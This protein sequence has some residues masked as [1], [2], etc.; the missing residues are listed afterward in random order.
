MGSPTPQPPPDG[1]SRSQGGQTVVRGQKYG[2]FDILQRVKIKH[3]ND[4]QVFY[5]P[6]EY[7]AQTNITLFHTDFSF[8]SGG[9]SR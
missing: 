4:P 2:E 5:E 3:I 8:E 7:N 9:Q 1:E 6:I